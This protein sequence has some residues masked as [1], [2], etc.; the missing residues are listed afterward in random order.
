MIE[1]NLLPKDYLKRSL[2]FS[3]G[4]TGIYIIAAAAGIVIML[5]SIT[6]YQKHQLTQLDQNIEKARQRAS[7]LQK[8]IRMVDALIDVKKKISQRMSAVEKLDSHRSAWIKIL[9]DLARNIPEFVWLGKFRENP[10]ETGKNASSSSEGKPA[11]TYSMPTVRKGEV[12]GYSFTLNALA[13]FMIKMMRSDY[14]DEVE[15]TSTNEMSL[16]NKKAYNFVL[17]FNIHYL[18]DDQLRKLIGV[19]NTKGKLRK[20]KTSHRSL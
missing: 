7:M 5:I 17:S 3:L 12:E 10:E 15:L 19:T 9:E 16:Q 6:F 13:S 8:D 14:F 1:I 18:S 4:K 2:D 11:S 20:S